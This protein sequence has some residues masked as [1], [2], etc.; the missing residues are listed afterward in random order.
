MTYSMEPYGVSISFD[1]KPS[2]RVRSILKSHGFRWNGRTWWRRRVPGAADM[3]GALQK[4]IG[5]KRPD[6]T[7]WRCKG[8]DGYF[9]GY[10]AAT[11]VYCDACETHVRTF[12]KGG[13]A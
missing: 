12:A 11:P 3:I 5:P 8:P 1:N 7:C 6:G 10:G 4:I 13:A 9:R 2:D